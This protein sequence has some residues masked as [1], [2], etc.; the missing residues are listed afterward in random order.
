MG[1]PDFER[2]FTINDLPAG[3]YTA[4]IHAVDATF[5]LS[6]SSALSFD[7]TAGPTLLAVERILLNKVKLTWTDGPLNGTATIVAR[8]SSN[9]DFQIIAELPAN[10][11]TYTDSGLQY[12]NLY[13][14]Q[15][16]EKSGSTIT[17][18]SNTVAWNTA[19]LILE[20][21]NITNATGSLDVGDYTGDGK[22][23]MLIFGGR[24][25]NG[26]TI[27]LTSALLEKTAGGWTQQNAGS[28]TLANPGTSH[29][30][31]INGDHRLDLYQHG[32]SFLDSKYETKVLLNNGNKSFTETTNSFTS[33][34][35]GILETWDYDRD[36]DLDYYVMKP[37]AGTSI[38]KNNGLVFSIRTLP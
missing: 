34:Y 33:D 11:T 25:F 37:G 17:T 19:L 23:D 1:M 30:Y 8:K 38:I 27:D 32:Y 36:N 21:S 20:Q 26:N 13:T 2:S 14:Y 18:G 22:M 28:V 16:Y 6:A 3:H 15:V 5:K 29:F 31:D 4:N 12:D 7:I 9:T 35:L 24:I 10:A